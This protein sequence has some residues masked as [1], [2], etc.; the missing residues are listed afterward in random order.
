M[1]TINPSIDSCP[2]GSQR[3]I[4]DC[5]CFNPH[6]AT[7]HRKS[8]SI[9]RPQSSYSHPKCYAAPLKGCS[10]TISREHFITDKVLQVLSQ[11]SS[12]VKIS[13]FPWQKELIS[14]IPIK[15][16]ASN[17]LC[18][19]HNSALSELDK[20][21]IEFSTAL[22]FA[23]SINTHPAGF[24]RIFLFNGYDI[25][26]W[27]LKCCMGYLVSKNM[28]IGGQIIN[29]D[30]IKGWLL[31]ILFSEKPLPGLRG[32]YFFGEAGQSI[33]GDGVSISPVIRK[34]PSP[35]PEFFL[36][37]CNIL[38]AGLF[39][40]LALENPIGKSLSEAFYRP[41]ELIYKGP[42]TQEIILKLSWGHGNQARKGGLVFNIL[43]NDYDDEVNLIGPRPPHS[44]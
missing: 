35:P 10:Q 22:K 13:G 11:V 12:K 29:P 41:S 42:N 26:K 39:F 40:Q 15:N 1:I 5:E 19:H 8:I 6:T 28:D 17:I 20:V 33:H 7:L 14:E 27:F 4:E 16:F 37:G 30:P 36:S 18:T 25:E 43:G 32:M 23:S 38:F 24:S 21:G 2:C 3:I 34:N 44:L 31:D 9:K